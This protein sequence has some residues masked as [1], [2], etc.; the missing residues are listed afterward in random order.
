MLDTTMIADRI[1]GH[2]Q[3][4][5]HLTRASDEGHALG[6]CDPV[7]YELLRRFAQSQYH[8]EITFVP[9]NDYAL[10][11]SPHADRCRLAGG[12]PVIGEHAKSGETTLRC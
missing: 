7:R 8:T 10:D 2:P 11:G 12:R 5:N 9:R 6:L 4:L 3:V 1:K